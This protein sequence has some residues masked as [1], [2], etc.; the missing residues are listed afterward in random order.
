MSDENKN[1]I[2]ADNNSVDIGNIS[3]GGN[4]GNVNIHTGY[5]SEQVSALIT[6]IQSTFQPKPFD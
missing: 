4:I 3:A 1:R 2:Q 6:Q 5:T